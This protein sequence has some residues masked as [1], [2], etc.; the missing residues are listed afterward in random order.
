MSSPDRL[1]VVGAGIGGLVGSL[2]LAARGEEVLLLEA[3]DRP[4]GKLR[5]LLADGQPVDSGPTVFT[6]KPLFEAIFAEAGLAFEDHVA[7]TPARVL[8]RHAWRDG[9]RLDLFADRAQSADAIAAFAGPREAEGYRA[10]AA[11]AAR[12]WAALERPYLD[13]QQTS[14]LGLSWRLGLRNLGDLFA[15]RPYTS[16]W[17]ALG[18]HFRDPRLRQLFG[19]YATYA[20]CSPFAA[21][22]TLMLIAHV[23]SQGVWLVDGGM[24]ALAQGLAAAAARAGAT[25]RFSAP[26]A[27]I[28]VDNGRACGVRLADGEVIAAGAVVCNADPAALAAGLFGPAAARAV[29]PLAASARSLSAV[30]LSINGSATGFP[31]TRHNIFFSDDYRQE[32]ADLAGGRLPAVP[33]LYV[34]AQDRGADPGDSAALAR[35]RLLVII[36]APALADVQPLPAGEIE[37]CVTTSLER[38]AG[39]GLRL[40]IPP[41]AM[42]TTTPADFMARFP[43]AG[44]AIYGRA[45]HGPTASFRRPGAR[46]RIPGLY[47]VGGGVHPGAGVP[48]VALSGRLAAA[49]LMA[50]RVSMSRFL[51]AAMPGGISTPSPPTAASA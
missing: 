24:Q 13:A 10:F 42:V 50:D 41:Q 14:P 17:R 2:L 30:T 32:F 5:E 49:A 28:L 31:L 23:E 22:A 36:N 47:L 4:G 20:G 35:E 33:T 15:L 7:L 3:A 38:L 39:M 27:E 29:R 40:S 8:A 37:R 21:P 46:S 6:L 45:A 34:C 1:V 26:V 9:S 16:M 43:G 44:G 11:E 48:M 18:G 12:I 25:L 51:P 19:R